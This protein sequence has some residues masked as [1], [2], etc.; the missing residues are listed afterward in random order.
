MPVIQKPALR[1]LATS[2]IARHDADP[3]TKVDTKVLDQIVSIVG[4]RFFSSSA[5]IAAKLKD[6][7]LMPEE[8]LA[9]AR[10]GLDAG[11]KADVK[12]LLEDAKFATLLDPVSTNFLKALIGAEPLRAIDTVGG[13]SRVNAVTFVPPDS[14]VAAVQKMRQLVTGGQLKSYYD[15]ATGA[16]DNP[17][18]KEEALKL[19][20]DLPKITVD[21]I[22]ADKMVALKLWSTKPRGIEEMQN[23]AR[24]LPGR[25]V[26]V[27]TNINADAFDERGLLSYKADGPKG[28]TYRATLAGEDGDNFL[29]KIDG[30]D[31]PVSVPK[32]EIYKL[33]QPHKFDGDVVRLSGTID[34]NDPFMKAK[35]AEA[36]IKMDSLVGK[37]DFTKMA[38]DGSG[39]MLTVFNRGASAQTMVELQRKCVRVTHDVINMVYP[40][41]SAEK[42][43]GCARGGNAGRLAVNGAGVCYDQA[44]VMLGV[45]N[46]FREML[47]VDVK[48]ISGGVFRNVRDSNDKSFMGQAH[49]W[50][51]LTYRPSMET[52]ICDRTWQQ[53]DHTMDKA[54]SRWGDRYPS[55][56]YWGVSSAPV[57]DSDTNF[58][59]NV[60]VATF[61][62]Q[63]G[64]RG[65]DGRDN[66]MSNHQ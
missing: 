15:A 19:F 28:R 51:E 34:Y 7:N 39:G 54:Y 46:P 47:G 41:G 31:D 50:L 64:T 45:L 18:L 65:V 58:S 36:A 62:R 33:N 42:R 56:F 66:H 8:K 11:E 29:V 17:A 14:E 9:L 26:V 2:L 3:S 55:G 38:T 32:T 1:E 6:G 25:Q 16:V 60:S 43:P 30:K 22:D 61:D 23:S 20:A 37:L 13:T 57:K 21:T 49:G 10:K 63:F 53:P 48:F 35:I 5:S 59:G 24:Y 27:E 40:N 52:R 12:T 4:D 44:T